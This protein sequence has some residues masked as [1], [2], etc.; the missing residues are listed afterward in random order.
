LQRVEVSNVSARG[1]LMWINRQHSRVGRPGQGYLIGE[2]MPV[3]DITAVE[4]RPSRFGIVDLVEARAARLPGI[5][6]DDTR[7]NYARMTCADWRARRP[8]RRCMAMMSKR[9]RRAAQE[10]GPPT[11]D[12]RVPGA[13]RSQRRP[14]V[15]VA[16]PRHANKALPNRSATS[17]MFPV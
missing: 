13:L 4:L 14:P 2:A 1:N 7:R 12:L 8:Q 10:R 6:K 3:F 17:I 9:G 16:M 5:Y 11:R 15:A